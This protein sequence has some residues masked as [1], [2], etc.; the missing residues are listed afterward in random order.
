MTQRTNG[1]D[2][3]VC[4]LLHRQTAAVHQECLFTARPPLPHQ[5]R[6]S[7]WVELI[8][9]NTERH[10][11]YIR[12]VNPVELRT[13]E[14]RCAHHGVI[15]RGGTAVCEICDSSGNVTRK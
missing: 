3:P 4:M 1:V 10:G 5:F 14:R 12:R 8:E 13:G 7:A 15:V 2:T 6:M 11:Q 9:V